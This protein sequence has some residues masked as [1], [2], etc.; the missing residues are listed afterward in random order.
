MKRKKI[1]ALLMAAAMV[2]G[3]AACS[4][5]GDADRAEMTLR[6]LTTVENRQRSAARAGDLRQDMTQQWRH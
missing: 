5:G 6:Q 1:L 2:V 4:G 3:L